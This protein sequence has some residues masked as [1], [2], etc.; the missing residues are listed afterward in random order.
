V[1]QDFRGRERQIR[2]ID[3]TMGTAAVVRLRQLGAKGKR[4]R[5]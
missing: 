1:L 5:A 2:E 3:L 4:T